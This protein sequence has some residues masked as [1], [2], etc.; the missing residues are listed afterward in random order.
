VNNIEQ[1]K[2]FYLTYSKTQTLS[3]E[4]EKEK[5]QTLSA[6]SENEISETTSRSFNL[7]W[8]HYLKLIRIDDEN[9]RQ[10]YEIE[11]FKKNWSVIYITNAKKNKQNFFIE[12]IL[13]Q[14]YDS[15]QHA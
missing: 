1:L 13:N 6:E 12:L 3:A 7:S 2:R 11:S 10:F 14:L 15:P 4:L 8:S 5:P 9:E